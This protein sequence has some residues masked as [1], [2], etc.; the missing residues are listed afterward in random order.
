MQVIDHQPH[1]WFLLEDDSGLLLDLECHHSAVSCSVL[2]RLNEEELAEYRRDGH[3]YLDRLAQAIHHSA[4][5][6]A[7]STSPYK[8][9]K[10]RGYDD[11]VLQA[12]R[13]W[14][15]QDQPGGAAT[16]QD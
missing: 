10:L 4:P 3:A 8:A 1:A 15:A 13:E 9:R 6:L 2:I 11:Q 12:I 16:R 7:I 14:Q 5:I